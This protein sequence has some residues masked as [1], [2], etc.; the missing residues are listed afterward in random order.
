MFIGIHVAQLQLSLDVQ[1]HV[2]AGMGIQLAATS[3]S[4]YGVQQILRRL[5]DDSSLGTASWGVIHV[6]ADT[7]YLEAQV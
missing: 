4:T 5:R 3:A 6:F 1:S 2:N 7:M